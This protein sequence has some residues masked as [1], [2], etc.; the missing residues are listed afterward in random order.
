VTAEIAEAIGLTRPSGALVTGV[1]PDGPAALAGL[2]VGDIVVAMDGR[3]I[4]DMEGLNFRIATGVIGETADLLVKRPGGDVH[5][6]LPLEPPP[7]IP[8]RD[9]SLL[10]GNQPIAGATVVNLSPAVAEELGLSHLAQGVVIV[11]IARGSAANRLGF[12]RN[13]IVLWVNGTDIDSVATLRDVL[14]EHP[15]VWRLAIRR[16]DQQLTLS[17]PG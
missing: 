11:E 17:V 5:I 8:P 9:E 4:D 16:G 2:E 3:Q 1:H 13:D 14:A 7:E 15:D 6:K 12:K 10:A